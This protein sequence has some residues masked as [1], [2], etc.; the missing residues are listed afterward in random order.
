MICAESIR[1]C[2]KKVGMDRGAGRCR[3]FQASSRLEFELFRDDC[4]CLGECTGTDTESSFDDARL[5]AN[6]LRKVEDR[7]LALA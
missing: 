7:R 1:L 5:A 4:G 6:V 3:S 2:C